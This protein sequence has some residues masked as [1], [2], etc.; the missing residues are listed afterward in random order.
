VPEIFI[1]AQARLDVERQAGFLSQETIEL[2]ERFLDEFDLTVE[3][4]LTFP[5]LGRAWPTHNPNLT[6]LRRLMM[7]GFPVSIFYRARPETLEIIRV[8]H[9][10]RDLPSE[11]RD[12]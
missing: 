12:S 3:R 2:A 5:H 7:T 6:D 10:S 4:L 1:H 11:L 9:N 8:L